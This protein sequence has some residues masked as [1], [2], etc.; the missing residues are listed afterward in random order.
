MIDDK[1][2]WEA[3]IDYWKEKLL[4]SIAVIKRIKKF[5]YLNLGI[6]IF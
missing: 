1:L 2:K 6:Q 4:C 3:Q 5:E